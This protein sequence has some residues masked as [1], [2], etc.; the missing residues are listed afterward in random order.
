MTTPGN[1][2]PAPVDG[3]QPRPRRRAGLVLAA[4]GVVVALLATGWVL[5][6]SADARDRLGSSAP[7]VSDYEMRGP[8]ECRFDP[9]R[10]GLVGHFDV[11]S[12]SVGVFTLDLSA[13]TDEG[14]DNLDV[15]TPHVVRVTVPFYGDRGRKQFDVVVP[16]TQAQHADGYRKCRFLVN[17]AA[18]D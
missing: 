1:D 18:S 12:R 9:D 6:G 3:Q 4:L 8:G 13:V 10:G 16:L 14:A 7:Q 15:T 11:S 17:P 2:V 5:R